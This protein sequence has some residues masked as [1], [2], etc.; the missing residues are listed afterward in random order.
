MEH[1][2]SP[3]PLPDSDPEGTTEARPEPTRGEPDPALLERLIAPVEPARQDTSAGPE[4]SSS[5]LSS[6]A[7][8]DPDQ[9]GGKNAKATTNTT[10]AAQ[11]GLLSRCADWLKARQHARGKEADALKARWSAHQTKE[12]FNHSLT[13]KGEK[14]GTP[15]KDR[16]EKHSHRQSAPLKQQKDTTHTKPGPVDKSIDKRGPSHRDQVR[17]K[18]VRDK[19]QNA[20]QQH[21]KDRK[22]LLQKNQKELK[23]KQQPSPR[24]PADKGAGPVQGP[25]GARGG[26]G[27]DGSK[28]KQSGEGGPLKKLGDGLRKKPGT[29]PPPDPMKTRP[30]RTAGYRDGERVGAVPAKARAYRDGFKDGLH[31]QRADYEKEKKAMDKAKPIGAAPDASGGVRLGDGA[32]RSALTSGEVKRLSTYQRALGRKTKF[33]AAKTD[34]AK[35]TVQNCHQIQRRVRA[36]SEGARKTNVGEETQKALAI[37]TE[38]AG[39]LVARAERQAELGAKAADLAAL[40]ERKVA[41]RYDGIHKAVADSGRTAPAQMAHYKE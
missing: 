7:F 25:P 16:G 40:T 30:M 26:A 29:K 17:D 35:L 15:Q 4:G 39:Q 14:G 20:P 12:A 1:H 6:D 23:D 18:P 13:E 10:R 33:L 41:E 34:G 2:T 24:T 37:L 9:E 11:E 21:G 19:P 8:A 27:S 22:P 38:N 31:K 36:L 3:Q 28:P 32:D 5:D